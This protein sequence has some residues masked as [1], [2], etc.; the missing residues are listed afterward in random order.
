MPQRIKY[1]VLIDIILMLALGCAEDDADTVA[2]MTIRSVAFGQEDFIPKEYGCNG[3]SPPL[4]F[5]LPPKGAKSLAVVMH[6]PDHLTGNFTHWL[7]WGLPPKS[8]LEEGA[9]SSQEDGI[10]IGTADNGEIQYFGTCPPKRKTHELVFT[11]YALDKKL[12]LTEEAT[13]SEL[14]AAMKGHLLARGSLVG[15][16]TGTD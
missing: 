1:S 7:V 16:Y 3:K 4:S 15:Y 8:V 2:T 5:S 12:T 10:V 11:V 14:D 13:R 6:S 9:K